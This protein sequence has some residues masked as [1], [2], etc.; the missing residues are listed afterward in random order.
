LFNEFADPLGYFEICLEIFQ[1][2]DFRQTSEITQC[3][4]SIIKKGI[5]CTLDA[6]R[7]ESQVPE[8]RNKNE[9][10]EPFERVADAVRRLGRKFLKYELIFNP[11]TLLPMVE[12]YNLET[13]QRDGWVPEAFLD[14]GVTHQTL[15]SIYDNIQVRQEAPWNDGPGKLLIV[16]DAIWTI[17]AWLDANSRSAISRTERGRFPSDRILSS[18][19]RM[20][21]SVGTSM[22]GK[23]LR[24]RIIKLR[25]EI[26]RRY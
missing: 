1:A 17:Q 18:L 20:V 23:K 26:K 6:L 15:Y 22:A 2:A 3:W 13:V 25:E 24:D 9:A 21:G 12:K 10:A 8:G 11:P 14:A 4:D 16:T 7:L 19:E 5:P